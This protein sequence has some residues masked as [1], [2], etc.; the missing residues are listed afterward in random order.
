MQLYAIGTKTNYL[1][2]LDY[3]RRV[4]VMYARARDDR[5]DYATR[6]ARFR[7]ECEELVRTHPQSALSDEQK[8]RFAGLRHFPYN[9]SLRFALPLEMDRD[10]QTIDVEL[11][12]DGLLRLR[13]IG[14]VRFRVDGQ[15]L[16]L[17]LFWIHA[18]GGG[19]FLPFRDLTS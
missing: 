15:Y 9:P 5:V 4:A 8:A 6:L 18:Y 10:P 2:L 7:R 19:L 13:R 14:K 17:S 3:R 16:S 12:E 1:D 11:R